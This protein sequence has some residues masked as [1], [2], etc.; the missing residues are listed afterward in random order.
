M[1]FLK[2]IWH[3]SYI[4]KNRDYRKHFI[5]FL[6]TFAEIARLLRTFEFML[7]A[8]KTVFAFQVKKYKVFMG[9]RSVIIKEIVLVCLELLML[10]LS[11]TLA[12]W[13]TLTM[14]IVHP[15][16]IHGVP[17]TV[18]QLL[19]LITPNPS[20]ICYHKLFLLRLNHLLIAWVKK[21]FQLAVKMVKHRM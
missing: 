12:H 7:M 3:I 15:R 4:N 5:L 17:K 9:R 11:I 14:K 6:S 16:K 20:K 21:N 19:G 2:D 1:Q 13:K 10:F 18:K 8:P